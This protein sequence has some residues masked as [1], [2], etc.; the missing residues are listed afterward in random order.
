[1]DTE[2]ENGR[3]KEINLQISELDTKI[4]TDKHEEVFNKLH[5][6][7]KINIALGFVLRNIETGDIDISKHMNKIL[8]LKNPISSVLKQT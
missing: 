5:S 4:V 8:Y 6:A 3:H 1:M 7:T 2:I